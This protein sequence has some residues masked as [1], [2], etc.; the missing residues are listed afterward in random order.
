MSS[1]LWRLHESIDRNDSNQLFL[2]SDQEEIRVVAKKLNV[3]VRTTRELGKKLTASMK[4]DDVNVMGM[5]EKENL[6]NQQADA[7]M[8]ASASIK[9]GDN[10][11]DQVVVPSPNVEPLPC[12]GNLGQEDGIDGM[13][14]VD[15]PQDGMQQNHTDKQHL[16]SEKASETTHEEASPHLSSDHSVKPTLNPKELIQGLL[17]P[18]SSQD[19]V[20][21][22][23]ESNNVQNGMGPV[24][25]LQPAADI[26]ESSLDEAR[27]EISTPATAAAEPTAF[28]S[29]HTLSTEQ[30]S[31]EDSDE[32]VV[33][34]VPNPKRMS[35]QK[36]GLASS[37]RPSTAQGDSPASSPMQHVP[38]TSSPN[39]Q[40]VPMAIEHVSPQAQRAPH[41]QPRP[42]SSGPIAND[43][44]QSP[45]HTKAASSV[46][47]RPLSSGPTLIDPDAFGRGLPVNTGGGTLANVGSCKKPRQHSP[48]TSMQ[49]ASHNN[50]AAPT[51]NS[52]RTSPSRHKPGRSPHP[53]SRALPQKV[54]D[55]PHTNIPVISHQAYTRTPLVAPNSQGPQKSRFGAIG[56]PS[57][58]STNLRPSA[59]SR[60][61]DLDQD[62]ASR[63]APIQRP[64]SAHGSGFGNPTD[65]SRHQA[66]GTDP[67]NNGFPASRRGGHRNE[68]SSRP[69]LF[70]PELD[71]TGAFST[72]ANFERRTTNMPEVQYTL[73]SGTTREAARGKGKLWVG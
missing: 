57:K 55:A 3:A 37:S 2:L 13:S 50:G 19:Q 63:Q 5:L 6:V 20:Q 70:E 61:T 1:A 22:T 25:K 21:N 41:K 44:K 45:S 30:E 27:R 56:P 4:K 17:K 31:Q 40:G 47:A 66:L 52:P 54:E 58:S 18:P 71:R 26:R 32:E 67:V 42:L 24:H 29:K 38:K 23:T 28:T 46:H 35:A 49:S 33:V 16:S 8:T 59:A 64:R 15:R 60:E 11:A 51:Q 48:R 73:K 69:S 14:S 39:A 34:F 43:P 68:R 62:A 53:S 72:D 12:A 7:K 10:I 36:K 65:Q 9:G